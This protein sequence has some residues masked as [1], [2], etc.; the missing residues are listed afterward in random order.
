M[1][2]E[3]VRFSKV[4]LEV[5][6]IFMKFHGLP[7]NGCHLNIAFVVPYEECQ[8]VQNRVGSKNKILNIFKKVLVMHYSNVLLSEYPYVS[9]HKSNNCDRILQ[10]VVTCF[11]PD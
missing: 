1:L 8:S 11:F 5:D 4:L 2:G 3:K 9:D 10:P 6:Y 7:L